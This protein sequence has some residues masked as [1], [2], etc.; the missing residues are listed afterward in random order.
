[1]LTTAAVE[2]A[3]HGNERQGKPGQSSEWET[4]V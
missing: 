2:L 3:L 1:M 4:F